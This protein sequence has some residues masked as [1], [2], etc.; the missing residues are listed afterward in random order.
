MRDLLAVAEY[1]VRVANNGAN[2]LR[3]VTEG[4][5]DLVLVDV[6]EVSTQFRARHSI[7]L[8]ILLAADPLPSA[9]AC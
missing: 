7:L 5:P 3:L 4:P 8:D 2:A 9:P 6:V 1:S